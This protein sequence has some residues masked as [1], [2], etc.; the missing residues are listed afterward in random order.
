VGTLIAQELRRTMPVVGLTRRAA[1]DDEISWS[2]ESQDDISAALR[3]RGVRTIVHAAWDMR[4]SDPRQ[5]E[6]VCVQ[7]SARLLASAA[8]AGVE[9]I[10]FI[11]T[12]SAFE[13]C[14]SAYGNA[15]LAVEKMVRETGNSI[16]LRPGLVYGPP[17]GAPPGSVSGGVFGSIQQQVR[18]SRVVPMIGDGRTPQYLLEG[19]ALARTVAR[20]VRGE[21][22][23]ATGLPITL[24][25]PQPWPFRNLVKSIAAA[26]GRPVTL[27][28]VPWRLL[29]S[30]ARLAELAGINLPFRSDSIL[31]FVYSNPAPDFSALERLQID[32]PPYI[33]ATT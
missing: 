9:R 28:P 32:L 26:E 16:V 21:F 17:A 8:K 25:H 27:V 1:S 12:F 20:A 6:A 18:K 7:G 4:V 19:E 11:S 14:R 2:L 3:Q 22:D 10:V 15:K 13:G 30:G 24:A 23:A 33:P 5:I 29:Y 31:S